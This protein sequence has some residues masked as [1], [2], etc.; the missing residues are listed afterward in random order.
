MRHDE[1]RVEAPQQR[2]HNVLP[3]RT[4]DALGAALRQQLL[5]RFDL[6][7]GQQRQRL[8]AQRALVLVLVSLGHGAAE[9]HDDAT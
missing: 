9:L 8:R 1:R 2:L 5:Q 4:A 7:L 6:R 3:L